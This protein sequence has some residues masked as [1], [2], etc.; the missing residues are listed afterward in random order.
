MGDGGRLSAPGQPSGG[1]ARAADAQLPVTLRDAIAR[2]APSLA[3]L[4]TQVFLDTYATEG[5]RPDVAREVLAACSPERFAARLRTAARAF[6][7]AERDGHLVGFVELDG[8][9][10]CPLAAVDARVELVRLYVQRPFQRAGLGAMLLRAAEDRARAWGAPALW[11]DAWSGNERALAFYAARGYAPVGRV[12]HRVEDQ[13]YVN[14]VFTRALAAED[15]PRGTDPGAEADRPSTTPA[16]LVV[17]G[18]SG[19]GKSTLVGLLDALALP[20]VRCHEFDTIG[21]PSPEE[22][23][24]RFGG[25]EGFQAWALDVWMERLARND[26]GAALAVL[27]AQVRPGAVRQAFARHGVAFG[28]IVLVD[29]AYE[30]RNARLRGPRGQPELATPRMDTWAA[31]LRGQADALGLP[32]LDTTGAAP[33]A[34]RDQLRDHVAALLAA[35]G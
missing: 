4:A 21:I 19:A 5:I 1:F 6:I 32:V 25:G 26:D 10:P 2:D 9:S 7:L 14:V 3:A 31:Y 16:V 33:E 23:E 11:L 15:T 22:I 34:G 28:H 27:D 24:A 8:D 13:S 35:R 30:E 29:C 17:T 12:E 18:A 20:G